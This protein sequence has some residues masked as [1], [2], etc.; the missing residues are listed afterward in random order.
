[1]LVFDSQISFLPSRSHLYPTMRWSHLASGLLMALAWSSNT[2]TAHPANSTS[3]F[4]EKRLSEQ[5]IEC[6]YYPA[7]FVWAHLQEVEEIVRM[8]QARTP[9]QSISY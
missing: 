6:D 2:V 8:H 1:M 5:N 9:S 7:D 4:L 3:R